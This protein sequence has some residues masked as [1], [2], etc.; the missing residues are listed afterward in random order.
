M[1]QWNFKN[2]KRSLI[3]AG[4]IL[5]VVVLAVVLYFTGVYEAIIIKLGILQEQEVSPQGTFF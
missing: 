1:A 2:K 5:A 3:A 4:I